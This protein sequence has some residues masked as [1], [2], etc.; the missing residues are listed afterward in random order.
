LKAHTKKLTAAASILFA[1]AL[2]VSADSEKRLSAS[3]S[4]AAAVSKVQPEYPPMAKQ[5]K[6]EGAVTLDAYVTEEGSVE[7]VETVSGNPILTRAAQ[8]ALKRWKFTKRLEDGKPV[9]FVATVT[10]NFKQQ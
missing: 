7:R 10:F 3:E 1:T 4:I 8:D 2:A 5:L 6:V 9:R